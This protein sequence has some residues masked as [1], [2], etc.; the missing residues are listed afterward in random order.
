MPGRESTT[1]Q[2][3]AKVGRAVLCAPGPHLR[4][5]LGHWLALATARRGLRALLVPGLPFAAVALSLLVAATQASAGSVIEPPR[6]AVFSERL[7]G[8]DQ[9]LAHLVNA[10]VQ[11]AGYA[12]EV[13]GVTVL[14]N[15]TLLTTNRYELLVLPGARALPMCATPAIASYLRAGGDLLALGLPAW[16]SPLYRVRGEW[17]SRERYE[18]AIAGQRP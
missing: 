1:A 15:R 5:R 4:T 13:I 3:F 9:A 14:T 2:T 12:A 18:A 16:Q 10:Q 7:P 17:L 6:A 11:A 8:F